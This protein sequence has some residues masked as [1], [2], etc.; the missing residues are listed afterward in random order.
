MLLCNSKLIFTTGFVIQVPLCCACTTS[1]QHQQS[2]VLET[3]EIHTLV[4]KCPVLARLLA[5][6]AATASY[7]IRWWLYLQPLLHI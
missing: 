7:L 4:H 6:P 1:V 3:L 2:P 5:E